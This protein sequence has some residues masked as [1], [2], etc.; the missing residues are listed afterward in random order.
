MSTTTAAPEEYDTTIN[1][2]LEPSSTR[3]AADN[4]AT[5]RTPIGSTPEFNI[6]GDSTEETSHQ[7]LVVATHFMLTFIS[8]SSAVQSLLSAG[9]VTL[10]VVAKTTAAIALSIVLGD[11]GTGVFHWS[12]DNYGSIKTPVF[13]SVCVA[14][15]GT[16]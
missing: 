6:E 16:L 1:N 4:T 13:G 9:P 8:L 14:F 5:K 7:R 12:V 3:A 15:Q 10:A 2:S 11:F